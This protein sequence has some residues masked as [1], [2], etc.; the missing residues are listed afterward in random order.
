M[1][2]QYFYTMEYLP[3]RYEANEREWDNRHAVWN[4][5]DGNCRSSILYNFYEIINS[6]VKRSKS[7]TM[8]APANAIM[9]QLRLVHNA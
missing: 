4:F 6:I 7:V 3:T 9:A 2:Y 1:E 5:K 8:F